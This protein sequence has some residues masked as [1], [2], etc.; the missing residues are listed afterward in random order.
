MRG[1][2]KRAMK[3]TKIRSMIILVKNP[4]TRPH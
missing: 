3:G 2:R 1:M 4:G